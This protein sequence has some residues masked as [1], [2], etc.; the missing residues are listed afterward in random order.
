[1]LL[2]PLATPSNG[3]AL[4]AVGG[5]LTGFG[6][7]VYNVN[8]V[9]FRQRLCPPELLGRM[10]ASMR[11]IVWGVM[12]IGGLIGGSLGSVLGLRTTLWIG[13]VGS[14]LAAVW[15]LIS[16]IARMRDFPDA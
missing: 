9:S 2:F 4:F 11:F 7:V 1:M 15:L 12:P 16:P 13:A 14:S 6:S 8:Q 5:F 10:N 3:V